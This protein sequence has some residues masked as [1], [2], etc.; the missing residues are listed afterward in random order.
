MNKGAA[1]ILLGI[2]VTYCPSLSPA[3]LS[4]RGSRVLSSMAWWVARSQS[5]H[6][7]PEPLWDMHGLCSGKDGRVALFQKRQPRRLNSNSKEQGTLMCG[8]GCHPALLGG[9]APLSTIPSATLT[10]R[11]VQMFSLII[12]TITTT[13]FLEDAS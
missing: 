9:R 4:R 12:I 2:L 13:A 1:P 8:S 5:G 6:V 3:W 7:G 10:R 11:P